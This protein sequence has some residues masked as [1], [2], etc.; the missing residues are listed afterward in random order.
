MRKLTEPKIAFQT[1][2]FPKTERETLF[3]QEYRRNVFLIIRF[4]LALGILGNLMSIIVGDAQYVSGETLEFLRTFRFS[5]IIPFMGLGLIGTT[6]RQYRHLLYAYLG[7][8]MLLTGVIFALIL[9]KV[10]FEALL[11]YTSEYTLTLMALLLLSR[12]LFRLIILI[13]PLG[14]IITLGFNAYRQDLSWTM[15]VHVTFFTIVIMTYTLIA[16]YLLERYARSNFLRIQLLAKQRKRLNILA[17]DL[18]EQAIR[19]DLTGL[20]NRRYMMVRLR[21]AILNY[22]RY[23]QPTSL[24]LLDLDNFKTINDQFGHSAGDA[25]LQKFALHIVH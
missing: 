14:V 13:F 24:I 23:Q 20:F 22:K 17:H 1:F 4:I 10:P 11:F 9:R 8:G 5:I 18:K 2:R 25:I 19:D 3:V 16:S 6:L 7:I 15:K 12:F 21:E